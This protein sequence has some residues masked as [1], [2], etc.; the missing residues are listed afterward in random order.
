MLLEQRVE[1]LVPAFLGRD[2]TYLCTFLGMYRAFA[3][4]QQ[5]LELLF[6]RYGCFLPETE[7]DGGPRKQE[8]MAI[9]SILGTWLDHYPEDFF[10]PPDFISLQILRAY[11]GVHMPGSEL[12]CRD[13]LLYS[14]RRNHEPNEPESLA[15]APAPEQDPDVTQELAPAIS[16]VP[17]GTSQP[18]LPA[19]TTH[20]GS[21]Q[22][23]ELVTLPAESPPV[24]VV[25]PALIHC[26]ELE[27][28]PAP[29]VDPDPEQ[30]PAPAGGVT[31][32]LEQPPAAAEQPASAPEQWRML[33]AAPKDAL[34]LSLRSL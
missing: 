23:E 19:A 24:Q 2:H 9:S 26:Q 4:T 8:K 17:T 12:Q 1:H 25:V 6:M 18:R 10:Q 11:I 7:E 34:I 14:S 27:E 21:Q 20:P 29:L 3:T 13:R 15:M 31:E 32:G 33:A 16:V 30:P 22:L 5:V 28:T